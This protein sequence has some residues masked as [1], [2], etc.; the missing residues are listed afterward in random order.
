M[1]P[2]VKV[3]LVVPPQR[4]DF[5]SYLSEYTDAEYYIL[6]YVRRND[7]QDYR[8]PEFIR[9]EYFWSD[10]STP[11]S[12][13]DSLKPDRIVFFE[14]IDLRQIALIVAAHARKIRSLYLEHGAAGDKETALQRWNSSNFLKDKLPYLVK[15]F[16]KDF[17]D[18]VKS[19][20]FYY[21]V[22]KGF[23]S[24]RSY[25]QYISLPFKMLKS[26]PNKTLSR[27]I[28]QERI[29]DMAIVF[30][31]INFE[32]F[33]AYTGISRKDA[34]FTGVPF[35]DKYYRNEVLVKSHVVYIEHPYLEQG[36]L[37]WDS[38][39]HEKIAR[40]LGDFAKKEKQ[41]LFIKL[42]P[43]SDKTVWDNY[44]FLNNG[45]VKVL[46]AGNFDEL[47]LEAKMIMGFSSSLLTGLICAKKNIVLLGWH[48]SPVIFGV[49]FSKTG[50]CHISFS[51]N[52]LYSDFDKWKSHNLTLEN[53]AAYSE[54]LSRFNSPFDGKAT[55]RV[56]K[57][58]IEH[59]I[60]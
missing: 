13:L 17:V 44:S 14:I 27:N 57:T 21:S 18:I 26:T 35:F 12:L 30:N 43:F 1:N 37:D 20:I 40:A 5:Y 45:Y 47:Y 46:Q 23:N 7:S 15:R 6:Y 51:P 60:Y 39:H 24:S 56:L 53:Q 59:E 32:E 49:D 28:F 52:E 16:R 33:E 2:K 22:F 19:K 48:P 31:E 3:L 29:P 4:V 54:F 34:H 10:Y 8:L 25:W 42:H 11:Y 41:Q 38:G 9:G 55:K 58:I 36:L 50:L